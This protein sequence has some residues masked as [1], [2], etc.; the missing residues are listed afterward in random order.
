ML[1]D[2]GTDVF[3]WGFVDL[4]GTNTDQ[5]VVWNSFLQGD[6][7]VSDLTSRLQDI[8]DKIR[9]DDSIKKIKVT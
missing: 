4:Y 2:A 1:T 8:T 7:S 5:L 6:S 3:T 9:E